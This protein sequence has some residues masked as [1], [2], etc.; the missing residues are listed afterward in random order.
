MFRAALLA[1][2]GF[3]AAAAAAQDYARVQAV[4]AERCVRCHSGFDA[5]MGL[6]LI[7]HGSAMQGSWTGPV[8]VP[9]D[10]ASS[11][12]I[13]RISGTVTPRMPLDGPPWL[14]DGDIALITQW[15]ADG[16]PEFGTAPLPVRDRVRPA[17]GEAVVFSDIEPILLK[18]CIKCHSDNS[19]LGGPPEGLRLDSLANVLAGGERLAVLPGNPAASELS[20][21]VA[22]FGRPRMPFDG[23]PWL[24]DEDIWLIRDWI[25]QGAK[26][27]QGLAAPVPVGAR[28]R[29]RGI[30]TAQN[31]IDGAAF[32]VTG[33]TRIDDAPSI[34]RAAE[35]RA[36]VA[37]D[38]SLVAE[39]LRDR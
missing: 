6:Q 10:P 36:R 30:L 3:G 26:D 25:A 33:A 19:R 35:V 29:L 38:G 2:L 15:I 8:I 21:R 13:A 34:G 7:S 9:G 14:S 23:P 12:L 37:R 22:G 32:H 39:R 20:R 11:P 16:A 27:A 17:P 4:F 31:A 1:V 24:E 18:R 28:I 5:P